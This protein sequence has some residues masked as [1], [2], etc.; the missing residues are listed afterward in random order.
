MNFKSLMLCAALLTLASCANDSSPFRVEKFF[1]LGTNCDLATA[2]DDSF[3]SWGFLDVAADS[4]Q[5]FL[6]VTVSGAQQIKQLPV[7]VGTT[8][9]ELEN[10]NRPIITQQVISYR[11]SKRVGALPKPYISNRTIH[12]AINGA[13]IVPIQ[14]ISPELGTALFEGL[15]PTAG[16][17]DFVDITADVEFRGEYSA[18]RT[19]FTTGSAAYP[20]RA[21][22]SIPPPTALCPNGFRKFAINMTTLEVDACNYVGQKFGQTSRPPPP[23]VCCVT[24]TDPGC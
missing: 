16:L 17:E 15:T 24:A 3:T 8:T 14:L 19:P 20:I 9:L 22:R 5:F 18:S 12:F 2:G 10:R 13:A 11:L 4:P 7:V 23:S 6:G 21:Y 1:P